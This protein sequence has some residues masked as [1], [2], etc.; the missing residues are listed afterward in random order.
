MTITN[1]FILQG[2]YEVVESWRGLGSANGEGNLPRK[3]KTII[4][5]MYAEDVKALCDYAGLSELTQGTILRMSLQKILSIIP[6]SRPRISSY[7]MLIAFLADDMGVT[8]ILTSRKTK[9]N[10]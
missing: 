6:K 7:K 5:A 4:P 9:F 8:L 10:G 2:D 3:S 1:E